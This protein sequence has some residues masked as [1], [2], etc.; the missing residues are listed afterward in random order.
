VGYCLLATLPGELV[1]E[2]GVYFQR[3][4]SLC[5]HKPLMG[6][7]IEVSDAVASLNAISLERASDRVQLSPLYQNKLF[8]VSV[9]LLSDL[10]DVTGPL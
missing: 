5:T 9:H 3:S 6:S 4:C 8:C 10:S 2:I 1:C 7:I